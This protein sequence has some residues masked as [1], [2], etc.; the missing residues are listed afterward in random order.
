MGIR[1][2]DLDQVDRLCRQALAAR[3]QGRR[4]RFVKP[5]PE[6]AELIGFCGLTKALGV[7]AR[8]QAE[9]R[10]EPPGVEEEGEAVDEPT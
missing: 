3:R 4:F 2:A 10:E 5:S 7:E 1:A 9:E 8:G 6:L